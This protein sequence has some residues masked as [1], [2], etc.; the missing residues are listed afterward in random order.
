VFRRVVVVTVVAALALGLSGCIV[1]R[2]D[3]EKPRV[4][5]RAVESFDA[6]SFSGYGDLVIKRGP[7]RDVE[8]NGPE[9]VIER[10]E[11]Q[12]RGDTL[13]ID[14][15]SGW[16]G[17]WNFSGSNVEI[18][19][20]MPEIQALD[21]SGAGDVTMDDFT[22]EDFAFELSGAGSFKA[23]DIE[24]DEVSVDLSGAGAAELSGMVA[25]QTVSISGVGEYD[26]RDLESKTAR[27]EMSG[28]GSASVWAKD[29]LNVDLSGAGSVEYYG[30]PRVSQDISGVG[31]VNARGDR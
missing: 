25:N 13:H 23:Q 29:S 19:V 3:T 8:I 31:S 20:T 7:R 16:F 5:S 9:S 15:K 30:D 12:V 10:I 2:V 14:W 22:G 27:V 4:E 21:V 1:R 18:V 28:A 11:T 26:A 17:W 6:V 24:F